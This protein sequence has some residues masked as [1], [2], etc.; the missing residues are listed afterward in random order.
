MDTPTVVTMMHLTKQHDLPEY[1]V[2]HNRLVRG[3]PCIGGYLDKTGQVV[4][5]PVRQQ[6]TTPDAKA[7][8]SMQIQRMLSATGLKTTL[9]PWTT[10]WLNIHT[11]FIACLSAAI[12]RAGGNSSQAAEDPLI[13]Q[14]MVRA[15]RQGFHAYRKL[16]G[17]VQPRS[18][19][20]LFG[21][22]PSWFAAQ[23]WRRE[24]QRTL[25]KINYSYSHTRNNE[26]EEV[27]L[28]WHHAKMLLEGKAPLLQAWVSPNSK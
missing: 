12:V 16:G 28:I 2:G 23:Y 5:A 19:A 11:I 8:D 22:T 13:L 18:L 26:K 4:W 3:F 6:P 27:P 15:I 9:E 1:K 7:P 25:G 17:R 10:D 20:T 24:L 14:S 21:P